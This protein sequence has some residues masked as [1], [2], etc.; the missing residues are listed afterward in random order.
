MFLR[1]KSESMSTLNLEEK[2]SALHQNMNSHHQI[3]GSMLIKSN[4]L[5]VSS[6]NTMAHPRKFAALFAGMFKMIDTLGKVNEASL[7]L[8]NGTSVYLKEVSNKVILATLTDNYDSERVK[9]LTDYYVRK[10]QNIF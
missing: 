7:R 8:K 9:R 3:K 6:N 2:M 10:F 5:H 1:N 4:G